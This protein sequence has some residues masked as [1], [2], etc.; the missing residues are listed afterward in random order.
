MPSA[1]T[2]RCCMDLPY[3]QEYLVEYYLK[4]Y[5]LPSVPDMLQHFFFVTAYILIPTVCSYL[6]L[7]S[8]ISIG[9]VKIKEM[10]PNMGGSID[11]QG[12]A[13]AAT[14]ESDIL[15]FQCFIINLNKTIKILQKEL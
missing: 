5:Y 9:N 6:L 4:P 14:K 13:H 15:T 7:L 2:V 10:Q 11:V 8:S 12:I 1:F 3:L